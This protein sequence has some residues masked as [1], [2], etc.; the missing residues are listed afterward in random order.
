VKLTSFGGYQKLRQTER[1]L[2]AVRDKVVHELPKRHPS[3]IITTQH[4]L[5]THNTAGYDSRQFPHIMAVDI[6]TLPS[7]AQCIMPRIPYTTKQHHLH[8]KHD[9]APATDDAVDT[10]QYKHTL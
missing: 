8:I 1:T 5:Y 3:H 9:A 10:L 4:E 6:T 2:D 7:I